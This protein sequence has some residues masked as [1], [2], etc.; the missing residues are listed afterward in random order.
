MSP[1]ARLLFGAGGAMVL[2]LIIGIAQLALPG[3]AGMRA[4]EARL[5][6]V[7]IA[8]SGAG[9]VAFGLLAKRRGENR[10][11]PAAAFAGGLLGLLAAAVC[12]AVIQSVER[13]LGARSGSLWSIGL[14]W[15]AIGAV[16]AL[17]S[18]LLVPHQPAGP[19]RR[20]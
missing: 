15:G 18:I 13:L 4:A 6:P 2:R 17:A 3:G 16:V 5:L 11:V 9:A 10:D 19:E 1:A 8:L 14:L 20:R 12:L 7:A